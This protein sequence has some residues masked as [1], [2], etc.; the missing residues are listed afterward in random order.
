MVY[1]VFGREVHKGLASAARA[2]LR[3]DLQ[4]VRPGVYVLRVSSGGNSVTRK[5]VVARR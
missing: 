4:G 1:D 3:L 2:G 5:L